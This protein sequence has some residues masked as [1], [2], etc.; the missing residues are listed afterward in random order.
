MKTTFY[1][2]RSLWLGL[3]LFI[4]L[5][6]LLFDALLNKSA[7]AT[8]LPLSI[9]ALT[10]W[11]WFGTRYII[12]E[13]KLRVYAGFIPYPSVAFE[14]IIKVKPTKSFI[15]APAC[16]LDRILVQYGSSDYIIISPKN[17]E[18]FI[19]GL[20]QKNPN[21]EVSDAFNLAEKSKQQA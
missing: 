11:I 14:K 15:A 21:I 2:K 10:A 7:K 16:S 9:L 18:A 12:K 5:T 19:T 1:S 6:S 13:N 4:P 8:I 3:V 20:L 17:K